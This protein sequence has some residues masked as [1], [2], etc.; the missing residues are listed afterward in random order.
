MSHGKAVA[1]LGFLG[2]QYNTVGVSDAI[3][4]GHQGNYGATW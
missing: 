2:W 3:T 1:N 4:M